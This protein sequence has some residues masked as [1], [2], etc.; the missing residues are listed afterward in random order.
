MQSTT[1][2]NLVIRMDSCHCDGLDRVRLT[3]E[4]IV[5]FHAKEFASPVLF[6][7]VEVGV[8]R[9]LR[10]GFGILYFHSPVG[11]PAIVAGEWCGAGNGVEGRST[12]S[13]PAIGEALPYSFF[14]LRRC[15][16]GKRPAHQ[17]KPPDAGMTGLE[18]VQMS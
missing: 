15:A 14:V 3:H 5:P 17:A 16:Y 12:Q 7:Q 9:V 10:F 2:R 6:M 13:P 4:I 11:A 8:G 18:S 1:A